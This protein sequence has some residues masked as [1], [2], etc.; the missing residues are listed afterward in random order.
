MKLKLVSWNVMGLNGVDKR[1]LVKRLIHPEGGGYYKLV[2][3]NLEA[4]G[5]RGGTLICGM[6]GNGWENWWSLQDR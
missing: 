4:R 5:S 2:G 6:K 3:V 1:R